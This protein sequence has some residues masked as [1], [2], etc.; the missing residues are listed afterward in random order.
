MAENTRL[1]VSTCNPWQSSISYSIYFDTTREWRKE[2]KKVQ[3]DEPYQQKEWSFLHVLAIRLLH[4]LYA[5]FNAATRTGS[6]FTLFQSRWNPIIL[7]VFEE[8]KLIGC[9]SLVRNNANVFEIEAIGAMQTEKREVNI[10][11]ITKAVKEYLRELGA[12]RILIS[13]D[14]EN[15]A[16]LLR[17]D[18][19]ELAFLDDVL[20]FDL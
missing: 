15:M 18:G 8:D 13:I 6:I 10:R 19:F 4:I 11:E 7:E 9:C 2:L 16:D 5:R 1:L 3:L 14:L 20:Y 12:T 17:K